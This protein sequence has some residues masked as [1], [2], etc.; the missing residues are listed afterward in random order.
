[1]IH[2]K[3]TTGYAGTGKSHQLIELVESLPIETTI[4]IAP[5]HKAL[6]RLRDHLPDS[7]EIKTIHA[8]LGWI[9]TIN[10]NATRI[11]HIDST[12][13]LEKE[14]DEYSHI[15]IDEAGMMSEEMFLDII[16]KL[17]VQLD[18]CEDELSRDITIECFLDPYQLLPVKGRQIMTDKATTTNLTKQYR[19]ESPD[20]VDLYTKF[21]HYIEGTNKDDLSTPYSKNVKPLDITQFKQGDRLLAY[22]NKAVGAWN[23][24]IAKQLGI[25]SYEGQEVQLG[26]MIEP[27][28]IVKFVI[29]TLKELKYWFDIGILKLQNAQINKQFLDSSLQAL[30][31][32]KNINFVQV[33]DNFIYPVIIGI[34]KAN[35]IL[36]KAKEDAVEDRKKFKDV[37]ALG[38]AY[39]MD[40]G[41]ATTVHKSQGSEF[42]NIFIDK[43]DIQKSIRNNYY[44]NYA[45]LMYVSI[46]R[47]KMTIMI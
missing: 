1:M 14:L 25:T 23:I 34:G 39:I 37:Y 12:H 24:K 43:L 45:R 2:F 19:S 20:V 35:L 36:K 46:S 44:E 4:V 11:E 26:S 9:P 33:I 7:I 18:Y 13:K 29:P 6:A 8:L 3:Y 22:T 16:S 38:R 27:I 17:E 42:N 31:T 41:F 5:T 47:A 40:Y 10:E 30:I 15:I 21:V 28:H 32:N